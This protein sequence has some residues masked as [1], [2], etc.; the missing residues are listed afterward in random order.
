MLP[1]RDKRGKIKKRRDGAMSERAGNPLFKVR[2]SLR[3]LTGEGSVKKEA[4]KYVTTE[5]GEGKIS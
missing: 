3:E 5:P 2:N 1:C 4:R